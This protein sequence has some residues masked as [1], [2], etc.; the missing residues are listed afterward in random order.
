MDYPHRVFYR[1][2][3]RGRLTVSDAR[4]VEENGDE[5]IFHTDD[6]TVRAI[7]CSDDETTVLDED[8]EMEETRVD[9]VWEKMNEHELYVY[10]G[11]YYATSCEVY[12]YGD[13][14]G[15]IESDGRVSLRVNDT[16]IS[17]SGDY[18]NNWDWSVLDEGDSSLVEV[19]HEEL[20]DFF[21]GSC[22]Y[23][24]YEDEIDT[25]ELFTSVI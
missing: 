13:Y 7:K 22:V 12:Y 23:I 25:V 15:Q 11:G 1:E 4:I 9:Y 6:D 19:G 21:D 3:S 18:D 20:S 16:E 8:G 2:G 17:G 14:D 10:G 24:G 5:R